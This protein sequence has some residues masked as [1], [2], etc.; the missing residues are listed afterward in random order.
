MSLFCYS[1]HLH[2]DGV[3]IGLSGQSRELIMRCRDSTEEERVNPI[4]CFQSHFLIHLEMSIPLRP[5]L[6]IHEGLLTICKDHFPFHPHCQ[7]CLEGK[8]T[9]RR[10]IC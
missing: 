8:K 3:L 2:C 1:V 5:S 7:F 6:Y 9:L 4:W 10:A